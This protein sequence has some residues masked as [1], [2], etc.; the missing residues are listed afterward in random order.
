[1]R[2]FLLVCLLWIAGPLVSLSQEPPLEV[3]QAEVLRL[4]NVVQRI[5]NAVASTDYEW[6]EV[7]GPPASDADKWFISIL[8]MRQCAACEQLRSDWTRSPWLL[9]LGHP[10]DPKQSWS[11]FNVYYREDASQSF[12][13]ENLRVTTYP[14]ILV[15]PPRS[16]RFGDS[17]TVVFQGTYQGDPER[18]A[19][20]ISSAI[21][22]YVARDNQNPAPATA[23]VPPPWTP[24]PRVDSWN[25]QIPGPFP[26]FDPTIPPQPAPAPT[27]TPET[28][29]FPWG[30]VMTLVAAGFSLPAAIAI[31]V[32]LVLFIRSRRLAAGKQPILDQA[33]LDSFLAL[34]KSI[35]A[36]SD[37]QTSANK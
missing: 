19:R 17:S 5:D 16:G 8:S 30:A 13:F 11:H 23:D 4:G 10:T 31:T 32:W 6:M 35:A 14:T 15:Q 28:P 21:R 29:A 25:P 2:S 26:S 37:K 22:A 27:P 18:L 9:A 7:M 36:S 3:D 34:L 20:D 24:A 33:T 12:R 1:M